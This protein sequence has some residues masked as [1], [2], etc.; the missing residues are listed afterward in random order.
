M[1]HPEHFLPY[2]VARCSGLPAVHL[3]TNCLRMLAPGRE[4]Y[5]FYTAPLGWREGRTEGCSNHIPVEVKHG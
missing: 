2:D 4:E 5:Q 1:T 3:C